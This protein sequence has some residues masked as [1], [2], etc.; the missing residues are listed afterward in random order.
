M[1]KQLKEGGNEY[2]SHLTKYKLLQNE[3][4]NLKTLKDREEWLK[5]N[6]S[7]FRELDVQCTNVNDADNIFVKKWM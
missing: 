3:W 4:K 1:N 6:S 5:R 2:G 7:A